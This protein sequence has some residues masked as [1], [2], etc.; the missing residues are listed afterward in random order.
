MH[1]DIAAAT[2]RKTFQ[3]WADGEITDEEACKRIARANLL[4]EV[5]VEQLYFNAKWLG[6]FRNGTE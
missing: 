3:F 5:T 2:D 1:S 6:Y 4:D